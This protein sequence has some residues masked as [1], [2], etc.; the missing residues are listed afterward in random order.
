VPPSIS[1][2]KRISAE[3][4]ASTSLRLL[5]AVE[6]EL[7]D[8]GKRPLSATEAVIVLR[9]SAKNLLATDAR[10]H[11]SWRTMRAAIQGD[12]IMPRLTIVLAALAVLAQPTLTAAATTCTTSTNAAGTTTTVCRTPQGTSTC[13]SNTNVAG[14]RTVC[15]QS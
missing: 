14:T 15:R 9:L 7:R 4:V 5:L 12:D 6:H 11:P 1:S 10:D 2:R 3:S 13:R 8:A